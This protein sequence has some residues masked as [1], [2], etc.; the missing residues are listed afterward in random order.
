MPDVPAPP[1][2]PPP[3]PV[4]DRDGDP[5]AAVTGALHGLGRGLDGLSIAE[6][7]WLAA[8]AGQHDPAASAPTAPGAPAP[9]AAADP[10]PGAVDAR[11]RIGRRPGLGVYGPSAPGGASLPARE[12]SVPRG[13]ALP[14]ARELA[15]ALRPL[16]RVW[17]A[18]RSARLDVGET[19]AGY[20]RSGELLP[21][22]RPAPERWFDLTVVL[23]RSATMAVW[24]DTGAELLKVLASTGAFRTLRVREAAS[25]PPVAA[26]GPGTG[27]GTG[28][29][30][31]GY[32][33]APSPRPR[34]LVLVFS[35]CVSGAGGERAF[36]DRLR[37]WAAAAPTVLVNPLPS[38]IWRH[39]GL[40]LPAVR[41]TPPGAPGARNPALRFAVPPLAEQAY[42]PSEDAPSGGHRDAWLPLP[43]VGLTPRAVSRWART[44]MRGDPDGCEAV[45]LPG[46][47]LTGPVPAA[48]DERPADAT[49]LAE[50]FLRRASTPAVRL[51]VLCSAYPQLYTGLLHV[52][53]QELVPEA[54][55]A[56]LAEMVVGGLFLVEAQEAGTG[57]GAALG[58]PVLRFREGVRAHLAP[59]LGARDALR[60][61]E[62]L[63]RFVAAHA[64]APGRFPALVP[65]A[66]GGAGIAP[67]LEPFA[68]ASD[69]TLRDLGAGAASGSASLASRVVL[70]ATGWVERSPSRPY[71]FLSYAHTPRLGS[72]ATDSNR[73][74]KRFYRDLCDE[75]SAL[76]NLPA[77]AAVGFMDDQME[78]GEGW[79]ERLSDVL[80]TCRV[81]VPLYSPRYFTSESCGKEWYA[82]AQ[83]SVF[84]RA[85]DDEPVQ[86]VVPAV[87]VPVPP[88]QMPR[89]A[90]QL[91]FDSSS[92]GERYATDGLYGL[93]QLRG[94]PDEYRGVVNQLA[95][96]IVGVA[97]STR[98][99]SD[100]AV[101]YRRAPSA[102]RSHAQ[103]EESLRIAVVAPTLHDLSQGR[104]PRYYG[105]SPDRW[106]PYQP[107]S[108]RPLVDVA[109]D[110][111][112][113]LNDQVDASTLDAEVAR[114]ERSDPSTG[115][116]VL[117]VDPWAL[118]V[119]RLRSALI[120]LREAR[121]PGTVVLVASNRRDEQSHA[122]R[123]SLLDALYSVLP[124]QWYGPHGHLSESIRGLNTL[125]EF[126]AAVPRAVEDAYAAY[127]DRTLTDPP[128][129]A[130]AGPPPQRPRLREPGSTPEPE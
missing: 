64:A 17:P 63:T 35:D 57:A 87:W 34:R 22:F 2:V 61:R 76:V 18:G 121:E 28:A 46:P 104:D 93:I 107:E 96:R 4:P 6:L 123:T 33:G 7:I 27:A 78:A 92:F 116:L 105:A 100:G 39:S 79:A 36:W 16:R 8:T 53:R 58:G 129:D 55:A 11:E 25:W 15:R 42:G 80:S 127:L 13:T 59:R 60:T 56:D 126:G 102:F 130:P 112:F 97:E 122:A 128:P 45:L 101:D 108:R 113:H 111:A 51:A 19:V 68:R 24:Q 3:V 91:H 119:P 73:W 26:T 124:A 82:F 72:H 48:P 29:A 12:M 75:V 1:P 5:L 77:G 109:T 37:G 50:A 115:P 43:V 38:R 44:L 62:V 103:A 67:E 81:L 14:R 117:L 118:S 9:D 106:N 98:I 89:P 20:A 71:F 65:D 41:V 110:L 23:D 120:A 49:Q 85:R 99:E 125:E 70:S 83:R 52:I 47:G 84:Q 32:A 88:G 21:A 94:Y 95:V 69:R 74:V 54:S 86:A 40:D 90:Q 31:L 10:G 30:G 114:V 66:A